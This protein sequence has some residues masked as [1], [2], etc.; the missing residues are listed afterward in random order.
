[1]EIPR[2]YHLARQLFLTYTE[3]NIYVTIA[4]IL[5]LQF[6]IKI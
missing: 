2:P 1:M 5:F 6:Y 3:A 4:T